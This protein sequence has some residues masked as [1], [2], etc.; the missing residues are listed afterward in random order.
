MKGWRGALAA[1]LVLPS[2]SV[3]PI[4]G[5]PTGVLTPTRQAVANWQRAGL[6]SVGGIPAST[7]QCGATLTP[8]GGDDTTRINN[9][10]AACAVTT[11][12]SGK[13]LDLGPGTFL[14][15]AQG[16]QVNLNK[17]LVLRGRGPGVTFLKST[18]GAKLDSFQNGAHVA[19]IVQLGGSAAISN[20]TN[21]TAD[22][23]NGATTINVASV[24]GFAV[25]GLL[26]VDE[27]AGGQAMPDCCFNNG[28]GTVWAMSDYRVVWN[29]HNP[30]V[31]F[32]DSACLG[33]GNANNTACG[34]DGDECAYSIRCG[35]VVEEL[36]LITAVDAT[37]KTVTFDSP[38]TIS[39]RVAKGAQA[40]AYPVSS[41]VKYAGVENLTASGGD[42]GNIGF[43]GCVYCW[44][45]KVESTVW[46]NAG[47]FYFYS[48][49]F[50][51]QVEFS[52]AHDAAWPVNGGGGYAINETYGASENL[53]TNNIAMK[54]NKLE[55][56]RASG[57]GT[58]VS[59]NYIDDGYINGQT[60][61][62]ETGLNCSHLI[63]SHH[64]LHEGNLSW[65][66]DN[67]T[68]HGS[69]GHCTFFRN[70][71][72]GFRAPFTA[73]DGTLVDDANNKP[74]DN[75]PLRAIS[76]HF[77]AYWD[78]FVGNIAGTPNKMAGWNYR[79]AAGGANSGCSPAIFSLGWNDTSVSGSLADQ[80]MAISYPAQPTNTRT[81]PGCLTSGES[82]APIVDGNYDYKT[83]AIQWT[84]GAKAMP[85]SFYL[86]VKPAFFGSYPWPWVVPEST[87]TQ[88]PPG[89]GGRSGL[90]A[91]ARWDAGTPFVQP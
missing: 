28:T 38:L 65:N 88:L 13:F 69:V 60:S 91:K 79:C 39:Y 63:G 72:T 22:G 56:H 80:S 16:N 61:W 34:R 52:W 36:H 9:A 86:P 75:G 46:L 23:A 27:F 8:G 3:A 50:R 11:C 48:G 81:G 7:T 45:Y 85:S 18:N 2:V 20:T 30:A 12:P 25:G 90:P 68:T 14:I 6:Q 54:A 47:A 59:Y 76:D 62:V 51:S 35:G 73:L 4:G 26:H 33:Y 32:F 67:D 41:L 53:I 58:V 40:R 15:N 78:S 66:T 64:V 71:L 87:T 55:V 37:A 42:Q 82:C 83:G 49:A 84:S 77:T 21:L 57:A 24:A 5:D 89:P 44:A 31:G 19:S 1:V 74:G 29:Q 17:C 70:Y 10:I 43:V